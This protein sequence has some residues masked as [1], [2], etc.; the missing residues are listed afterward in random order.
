MWRADLPENGCMNHYYPLADNVQLDKLYEFLTELVVSEFDILNDCETMRLRIM[1]EHIAELCA[2]PDIRMLAPHT[3]D[4]V[5]YKTGSFNWQQLAD[6][7]RSSENGLVLVPSNQDGYD[8]Y[9]DVAL[10]YNQQS[11]HS[12]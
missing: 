6:D 11:G 2:N 3:V 1:P 8:N 12:E 5:F 4:A 7:F 10:Y 9:R